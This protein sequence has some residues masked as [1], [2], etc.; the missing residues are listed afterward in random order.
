MGFASIFTTTTSTPTTAAASVLQVLLINTTHIEVR[1]EGVPSY[2]IFEKETLL[3]YISTEYVSFCNTSLLPSSRVIIGRII[4]DA[5]TATGTS[6]T[7]VTGTVIGGG[8]GVIGVGLGA[9]AIASD[10]IGLSALSMFTC[11]DPHTRAAFGSYRLLSPF[12][13]YE[14]YAGVI[15]GNV[16]SIFA[17][18]M[19]QGVVLIILR[20]CRPTRRR[21][22]LMALGRF[23]A[24]LIN[25]SLAFQTGTAFAASQLIS[26]SD[27]YDTWEVVIGAIAFLYIVA[28]P[29]FLS[30]HPYLQIE[31]AYQKYEL[32]E[33]ASSWPRWIRVLMPG[34]A[35]YS[36]ETRAAYGYYVSAYRA[37]ATQVW[38]TSYPTW[39]SIIIGLGGLFHPETIPKCQAVFGMMGGALLVVAVVVAAS[40]PFRSVPASLMDA[41]AKVLLAG[42]VFAMVVGLSFSSSSSKSAANS[43]EKAQFAV[44]ILGILLMVLT[45]VRIIHALVCLYFDWY[46][47]RDQIPLTTVWSHIPPGTSSSTSRTFAASEDL[48]EEEAAHRDTSPENDDDSGSAIVPFFD[49]KNNSNINTKGEADAGGNELLEIEILESNEEHSNHDDDDASS[50]SLPET[51]VATGGGE[52]DALYSSSSSSSPRHEVGKNVTPQLS[53]QDYPKKKHTYG[54]RDDAPRRRPPSNS[55]SFSSRSSISSRR[56]GNGHN[57]QEP[58]ANKGHNDDNDEVGSCSSSSGAS[59]NTEQEVVESSDIDMELL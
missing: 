42:V 46:V 36:T 2:N 48:K 39:T 9:A 23:P 17:V 52:H 26:Q 14:S 24:V 31:R 8:V 3:I 10:Q 4:V 5:D 25:I 44:V 18:A 29:V 41:A 49:S 56:A 43:A 13:V 11:A 54:D 59:L 21:I 51:V 58:N 55:S 47:E 30:L 15:I 57:N 19:I 22:E 16:L 6:T 28:Y 45:L 50:L 20:L 38:W 32:S 27:R 7:S 12:A 34:G 1:L 37:P 40:R 53:L 35:V 33:W